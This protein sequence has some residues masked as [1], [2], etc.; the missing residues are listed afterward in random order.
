MVSFVITKKDENQ[1]MDKYVKKI[2]KEAPNSFIYK[3]MRKK[4]IVLNGKKCEGNEILSS[5]DEIKLFLSDETFV[6]FSGRE[7]SSG[8]SSPQISDTDLQQYNEAYHKLQLEILYENENV[9]FVNKPAGVLSQKAQP[10]DISVNDWL[11]GYLLNDNKVTNMSLITFKPSICNR[12]DRNTSGI[13]VCAK[14]LIGAQFMGQLI[15]SKELSK[16]YEA[17]IIGKINLDE[18]LNGFL[19]KDEIKNKVTIYNAKEKIPVDLLSKAEYIDTSLKTLKMY[20]DVT[21]L[22]V[23][24]FTGKPHQIRAHLS[25]IGHPILGDNKYG[26]LSVNKKYHLK[27]QLLH[28]KKIVFPRIIADGFTDLSE[29]E[30]IC[31]PP[32][33]FNKI[34]NNKE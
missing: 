28:A 15:S 7:I 3:M 17:V 32:A 11:I 14:T 9:L 2:L 23:Q 31:E 21:L 29:M 19:I 5:G 27:S 25:S 13:I 22:E 20:E 26:D 4:N 16:F 30:L 24:L 10:N 6:K 34:I 8:N 1:R 12:L 18:R 33:S